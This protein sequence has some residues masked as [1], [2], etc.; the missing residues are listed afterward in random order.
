MKSLVAS[1]VA[2]DRLVLFGQSLGTGPAVEM[3]RRGWGTRLVPLT[4]FTSIGDAAQLHFPF[5]PAKWLVGDRLAP[6]FPH[7]RLMTVQHGEH[8]DLWGRDDVIAR[9]TAFVTAPGAAAP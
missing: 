2:R 8:N 5:L 1:G 9:V 6:M 4:P 7:A 3:A